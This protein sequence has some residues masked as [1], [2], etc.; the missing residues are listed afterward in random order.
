METSWLS[1]GQ[2]NNRPSLTANR[3]HESLSCSKLNEKQDV[4]VLADNQIKL[5]NATNPLCYSCRMSKHSILANQNEAWHNRVTNTSWPNWMLTRGFL[6]SET[7]ISHTD[8]TK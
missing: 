5:C 1:N 3:H 8:S 6:E 2:Q 4:I 7:W